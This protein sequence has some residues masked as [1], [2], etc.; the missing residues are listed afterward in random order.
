MEKLNKLKEFYKKHSKKFLAV[1]VLIFFLFICGLHLFAMPVGNY[2]DNV[3]L[4]SHV[5]TPFSVE[6]NGDV[7]SSFNVVGNV[8]EGT[9][10]ASFDIGEHEYLQMI[11]PTYILIADGANDIPSVNVEYYLWN[12]SVTDFRVIY[13]DFLIRRDDIKYISNI[14]IPIGRYNPT[15]GITNG[16]YSINAVFSVIFPYPN[17]TV[18][19]DFDIIYTVRDNNFY[20]GESIY[21]DVRDWYVN[22]GFPINYYWNDIPTC[23][24]INMELTYFDFVS[25]G[26]IDAL[27]I[28][29]GTTDISYL[30]F[31]SDS[32]FFPKDADVNQRYYN[33][34]GYA[35][36][37]LPNITI[38]S[39]IVPSYYRFQYKQFWNE[40]ALTGT[41]ALNTRFVN[42]IPTLVYGSRDVFNNSDGWYEPYMQYLVFGEGDYLTQ[43]AETALVNPNYGSWGYFEGESSEITAIQFNMYGA[44]SSDYSA[45]TVQGYLSLYGDGDIIIRRTDIWDNISEFFTDTIGGFFDIK[46]FGNS[47]NLTIGG[48]AAFIVGV[49]LVAWVLKVFV[50]G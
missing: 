18:R 33:V 42:N 36:E 13:N 5:L 8:T 25:R 40:S 10:F 50:G 47:M 3:S 49:S 14:T 2:G 32:A 27:D 44:P 17:G 16:G 45:P 39:D 4:N 46:L 11:P 7:L 28:Q 1:T 15:T 21:N 31:V 12:D 29:N 43:D 6:I 37:F 23:Y 41:S 34:A 26:K 22:Y 30:D 48:I 20:L 19:Q 38:P 35:F 9:E 24:F